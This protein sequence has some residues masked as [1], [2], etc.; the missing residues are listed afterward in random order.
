MKRRQIP[1]KLVHENVTYTK[2]FYVHEIASA[3]LSKIYFLKNAKKTCKPNNGDLNLDWKINILLPAWFYPFCK[4]L[5]SFCSLIFHWSSTVMG[6]SSPPE[7][8]LGKCVLKICSKF[9]GEHPCRSVISIKLQSNFIEITL[10]YG[11]SPVNVLHIFKTTFHKNTYGGLP[12]YISTFLNVCVINSI[13][14]LGME[15]NT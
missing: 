15:K 2:K 11:H 6:R 4:L 12:L 3:N 8:F 14:I 1:Q 7:V 9:T 10:H 13:E 5:R